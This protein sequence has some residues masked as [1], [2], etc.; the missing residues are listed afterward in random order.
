MKS[1]RIFS[2]QCRL[3]QQSCPSGRYASA[4]NIEILK[5]KLF[6]LVA[7]YNTRDTFLFIKIFFVSI[8]KGNIHFVSL[9]YNNNADFC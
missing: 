8:V 9:L 3:L 7:L 2:V 4:V 1:Q 6:L 5:E